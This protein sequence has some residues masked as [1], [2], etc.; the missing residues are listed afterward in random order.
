MEAWDICSYKKLQEEATTIRLFDKSIWVNMNHGLFM[1]C[2]TKET[3]TIM[4][5]YPLIRTA[6]GPGGVVFAKRK[7]RKADLCCIRKFKAKVLL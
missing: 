3:Q 7:H 4:R 6:V 5:L 1:N 2:R